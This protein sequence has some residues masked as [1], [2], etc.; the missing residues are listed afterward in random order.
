[1]AHITLPVN[2]MAY[3]QYERSVFALVSGRD[4]KKNMC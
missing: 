4:P 2:F 3:L 1:M